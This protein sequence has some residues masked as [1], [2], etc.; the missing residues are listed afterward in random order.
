MGYNKKIYPNI[1]IENH[2]IVGAKDSSVS[3]TIG[4]IVWDGSNFKGYTGSVWKNLDL[5]T[6]MDW[7]VQVD[8]VITPDGDGTRDIGTGGAQFKD[9]Y[10]D[11]TLYIADGYL[12]VDAQNVKLGSDAGL[13]ITGNS[14]TFIGYRSGLGSGAIFTATSNTAI[15]V[16]SLYDITTGTF[17]STVGSNAGL[18]VTSGGYNVLVGAVTGYTLT[19]QDFNINIGYESGYYFAADENIS[20]GYQSMYGS[21]GNSS[22]TRNIVLGTQSG[23]GIRAGGYNIFMGYQSGYSTAGISGS[24]N[25]GI[26]HSTGYSLTSGA[27]NIMV[28]QDA[29]K[30][31]TSGA[32]NIIFG[33][34][35]GT[36]NQTGSGNIFL[37]YQTGYSSTGGTNIMIGESAGRNNTGTS[38]IFIGYQAA[39]NESG[40]NKLYIENSNSTSP[41]IYGEFDND[42]VKING[43]LEITEEIKVGGVATTAAAGMID[44]DGTNFRGYDGADWILL[45][46]DATGGTDWTQLVDA[47]ITPDGDATRNFGTSG[48]A[49]AT[50][51]FTQLILQDHN[52]TGLQLNIA[53]IGLQ[54]R[55]QDSYDLNFNAYYSTT[56]KYLNTG[57]ATQLRSYNGTMILNV[58][59]SGTGGNT[60]TWTESIRI[61][62]DGEVG[63]LKAGAD[64]ATALDVGGVITVTGGNSTNWNSA[65]GWGN[66]SGLYVRNN[67]AGNLNFSKSTDWSFES[68]QDNTYGLMIQNTASF[69]GSNIGSQ[70]KLRASQFDVAIVALA[71]TSGDSGKLSFYVGTGTEA[72]YIDDSVLSGRVTFNTTPRVGTDLIWHAGNLDSVTDL[73]VTSLGSAAIITS[74]ERT[75]LDGISTGAD[76]TL[77]VVIG[78][79][80]RVLVSNGSGKI[81]VSSSIT[82]TELGYLNGLSELIS[83]SLAGKAPTS[84]A[85]NASTYGYG[86][87]TNAGHLRVGTGLSVAS[88]TISLSTVSVNRALVSSSTGYLTASSITST[89]LGYLDGLGELI[90]TSLAAKAPTSHAVNAATYGYGTVTNAGHLR[91]GTGLSISSG[92]VSVTNPLVAGAGE[93]LKKGTYIYYTSTAADTATGANSIAIGNDAGNSLTTGA[94]NVLLGQNAGRTITTGIGNVMIGYRTGYKIDSNYNVA[95]GHYALGYTSSSTINQHYNTVIGAYSGYKLGGNTEENTIIGGYAGS[96]ITTG[97]R[98]VCIGYTAGAQLVSESDQLYIDITNTTTPLI[99]GNFNTKHLIINNTLKVI[100]DIQIGAV[101]STPV[102]GMMQWNGTEFQGYTGS[103]WLNLGGLSSTSP[104]DID[105]TNDNTYTFEYGATNTH[106]L[107]IHNMSTTTGTAAQLKLRAYSFETAIVAV[108]GA[109][110]DTGTL[111]FWVSNGSTAGIKSLSIVDTTGKTTF[112][113]TPDVDGDDI[114]HTGNLTGGV[115]SIV[116]SNLTANRVLVSDGSGKVDESSSISTTELGYLD[117][118][119]ELI[120]TSLAAKAP[121]SHAVNASTYGYGTGTNAGHLRVGTGLSIS[122]GTVS[123]TNLAQLRLT[124]T[125]NYHT[126][127]AADNVSGS[128]NIAIGHDAGQNVGSGAN[129]IFMGFQA[130]YTVSTSDNGNIFMG[131]HAGYYQAQSYSIG[132]GFEAGKYITG[133]DNIFIGRYAGGTETTRS[134]ASNVIIGAYAAR[135]LDS[136]NNV[137]IGYMAAGNTSTSAITANHNVVVGSYAGYDLGSNATQNTMIGGFAGTNISTGDRN[138]CIGYNAGASLTSQNDQLYIDVTSTS[139]PLIYGNFSSNYITINGYM[140]ITGDLNVTVDLDVNGR[141]DIAGNMAVEGQARGG[142]NIT[143]NTSGTQVVN[144]NLGNTHYIDLTV[145]NITSWTLSNTVDG[146]TYIL[147]LR[148]YSTPRTV[149]WTSEFVF[150]EGTDTDISTTNDSMNI[151]SG[152]YYGGKFYCN[153]SIH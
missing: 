90:S 125:Y 140:N 43:N 3:D 83:T 51:Y 45:D 114:W 105:F 115:T 16:D 31:T 36:A 129:N 106:G 9:F 56:Q 22:G 79:A 6:S 134:A 104:D 69:A 78:T 37:G 80:N 39:Y 141:A 10:L 138:I 18:N 47:V 143:A 81:T 38:N 23:Y 135:D 35:A 68:G 139:T 17:N 151:I 112:E 14:N 44:W 11:G 26:G 5:T 95:I 55:A 72:M 40:S 50:G 59:P 30:L 15:G 63:I 91:V 25:I 52:T 54:S 87:G 149:T 32:D 109:S 84:H 107:Q 94:N 122:S 145:G 49:F 123:V 41:L 133:T 144:F 86:T 148:Q 110:V 142:F 103:T 146:T 124:G 120:S 85:V 117:G 96:N 89:E 46:Q 60:I 20:L 21:S 127:T 101:S 13:N 88:G 116:T 1:I 75:K 28:G 126:S 58:A 27:N 2:L 65:Y 74:G 67:V 153:L 57:Y 48:A 61:N 42:Y 93:L 82:T 119:G 77:N 53:D 131:Y 33:R 98:N 66:H 70:L 130:G 62:N 136:N 128:N 76:V 7:S 29:G 132:I 4:M 73:D 152:V 147:M 8:D 34:Q 137:I 100:N 24:E 64:P 118:L 108:T 113:I 19:T 150:G 12:K 71:D 111:E 102:A 97:D 92:T 121:T 99:Q